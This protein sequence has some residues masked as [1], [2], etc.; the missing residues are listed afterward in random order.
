M[1]YYKATY[2]DRTHRHINAVDWKDAIHLLSSVPRFDE[3]IRIE[4]Q[5]KGDA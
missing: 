2:V 3:I 1:P 5:K 4:I